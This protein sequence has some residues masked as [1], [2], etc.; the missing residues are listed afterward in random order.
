[1]KRAL[2]TGIYGQDGGFLAK[3][4]LEEGCEVWGVKRRSASSVPWRLEAL[5]ILDH[6]NLK[7]LEGDVTD[8]ISMLDCVSTSRPEEVYN[9]AAMSH[10][11]TSFKQP[12]ATAQIDGLGV[13]NILEAIRTQAPEARFVQ[14]S[15]SEL[16]G[17][18]PPEKQSLGIYHPRSPYGIAKL[19][20]FWTTVNY[21]E[22][23]NLFACNSI[24]Y[25]HESALRGSEFVTRKIT[26][27]L[28]DIVTG[29]SK[30]IKL[31]NIDAKR[32]WQHAKDACRAMTMMARATTPDDFVVATGESHSVREFLQLAVR[33]AGLGE[34]YESFIEIDPQFYRPAEV[35]DLKG[36]PTKIMK[37]LGWKPTISYDQLV[38]EMVNYDV[39]KQCP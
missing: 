3:Q 1:M 37:E 16:Y 26:L 12:L 9:T 28:A 36:N 23:Y 8:P 21:R 19:F 15:T 14:C 33:K 25:N 7:I 27:G 2:V 35:P 20:G 18:L 31:G 34:D 30:V 29:R 17:N 6:P 13:L 32:D 24:C 11:G 38:A 10:V 22:T 4:L 39:F 5:G